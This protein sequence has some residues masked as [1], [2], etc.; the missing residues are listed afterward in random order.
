MNLVPALRVA[1]LVHTV[2]PFAQLRT[3]KLFQRING[4]RPA[5]VRRRMFGREMELHAERSTMHVL[6]Y[7]E[8]EAHVTD[9]ALLDEYVRPGATVF[10][11]G[12]N[13][14]YLTLYFAQRVGPTGRVFAFEPEP[15]NYAELARNIE[16]NGLT[17]CRAVPAAVGAADGE[18][19]IESGMNGHVNGSG[20]GSR[21]ALVSLDSFTAKEK[22]AKVDLVKIDV[23][24]YEMHVLE[25]MK[26]MLEGPNKPIIFLEVHPPG[27]GDADPRAIVDFIT[28]YYSRVE[29]SRVDRVGALQRLKHLRT[30]PREQTVSLDEVRKN[31]PSVHHLV[32][33]P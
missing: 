28:K 2:F 20:A 22:I 14:G 8:G 6:I 10:D 3:A 13:I 11:V 5:V 26:R 7:M 25:G 18:I 27:M 4:D 32:C 12:G 9:A 21:Q 15:A 31:G 1:R 16:L 29:A 33:L 17:Q 24:G 30:P 23:E 19:Y